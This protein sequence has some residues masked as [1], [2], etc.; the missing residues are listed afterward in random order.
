MKQTKLMM[1]NQ[2]KYY[3]I[4]KKILLK[5]LK[6]GEKMLKKEKNY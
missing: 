4:T 5:Q 2:I 6:T 1:K 3:K